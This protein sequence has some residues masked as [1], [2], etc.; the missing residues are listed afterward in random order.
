[1][2]EQIQ[3]WD[4]AVLLAIQDWHN[5][6]L[7]VIMPIVSILGNSGIIWVLLTVCLL[8]FKRTRKIGILVGIS[9]VA[10]AILGNF[11]LKPIIARPRPFITMPEVAMIIPEPHG[12]SFPSGHTI[13][14]FAAATVLWRF[15][16]K[17]ALP[18]TLL[19]AAIGFSRMYLFCHYTTDVLAGMLIGVAVALLTILG[20][21]LLFVRRNRVQRQL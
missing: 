3:Q 13:S 11:I 1:M 10:A 21:Q 15:S 12:Y 5:P 8:L 6:V 2:F 19:A 16:W 7:D 17:A 18:A 4:Q 20:Y 9:L 14:S